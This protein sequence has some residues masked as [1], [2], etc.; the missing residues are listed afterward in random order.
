MS[1]PHLDTPVVQHHLFSPVVVASGA[2]VADDQGAVRAFLRQLETSPLATERA[3]KKEIK[4]FLAWL[5]HTGYTPGDALRS[6]TVIDIE[7]YFRMLRSPAF[8]PKTEQDDGG[9]WKGPAPLSPASLE[10]AKTLLANFFDKLQDYEQA[11]GAPF[12]STNPVRAMGRAVAAAR[13]IRQ[14]GERA[15]IAAETNSEKILAPED[16]KLIL[17]TLE[18]MPRET[19]RAQAHYRRNRWVLLLAYYSWLRLSELTRLQMGDIELDR[20]GFWRMYVHPSKHETQGVMIDVFPPLMEALVDYRTSLKKMPFPFRGERDPA[21]LPIVDK[22]IQPEAV[23]TLLPHGAWRVE[24]QPPV[25]KQL[26]DRAVFDILKTTFRAAAESAGT[27]QQRAR[28]RSASPHWL[29]HSG[30]THALNAGMDPRYVSAQA[31]HQDLKTTFKTYD[32]GQDAE[33][34]RRE[35]GK[36]R[37]SAAAEMRNDRT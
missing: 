18:A 32:H 34:R 19:V 35:A 1:H 6:L 23:R 37:I 21:I 31:R 11:P 26:T 8:L 17:A 29:R 7:D 10:H 5:L 33:A 3:Y 4:R 30:I 13:G 20:E 22:R 9:Y 27:P 2:F 12:R 24:E 14:P 16:I 15:A 36:L 28:L 25:L